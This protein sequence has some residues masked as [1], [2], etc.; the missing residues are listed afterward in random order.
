MFILPALAHALD[1]VL[2][3]RSG[4]TT[5]LCLHGVPVTEPGRRC[6]YGCR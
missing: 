3:A 4:G 2:T 5:R 1:L 6:I